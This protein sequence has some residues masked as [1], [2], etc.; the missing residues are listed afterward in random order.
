[1]AVSQQRPL[2]RR[3]HYRR[4]DEGVKGNERLTGVTG[5]LLVAIL[6]VIGV[7]ILRIGQLIDVHL[8]VGMMLLA[9]LAL[10]LAST[11]WRFVGYYL[12]RPGY[13]RKGPPLTPLR[14]LAAPV[15]VLTLIVMASG[16]VMLFGGPSTLP[17]WLE[18]HKLSFIAWLLVTAVHVLAH[19]QESLHSTEVELVPRRSGHPR[20]VRG[21]GARLL[22]IA[23]VLAFGVVIALVAMPD[24]GSWAHYMSYRQRL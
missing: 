10:K 7:S 16:L 3:S 6:A 12:G 8:F 14:I 20:P 19:L 23:T 15:V 5:G 11:G 9:P 24:F 17:T 13:R 1:M 4:G 18:I 21:R 22:L 2:R